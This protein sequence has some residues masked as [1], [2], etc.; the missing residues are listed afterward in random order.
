MKNQLSLLNPNALVYLSFF[1]LLNNFILFTAFDWGLSS[2]DGI[3]KTVARLISAFFLIIFLFIKRE[4]NVYYLF[5]P[6]LILVYLFF[7]KAN[8][9]EKYR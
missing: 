4:I 3:A 8:Y 7:D 6:F 2:E 9:N 5:L 1:I